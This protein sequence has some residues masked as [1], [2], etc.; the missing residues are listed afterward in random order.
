[1][2]KGKSKA[3]CSLAEV[4]RDRDMHPVIT[5][6]KQMF[7]FFYRVTIQNGWEPLVLL[8][9]SLRSLKTAAEE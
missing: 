7:L 6:Y 1:M 8:L 9:Y 5:A 3:N 4:V 2:K